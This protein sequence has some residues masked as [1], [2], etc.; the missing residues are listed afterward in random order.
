MICGIP[1]R[2]EQLVF[3]RI[4]LVEMYFSHSRLDCLGS[5]A[6]NHSLVDAETMESVGVVISIALAIPAEV[7]M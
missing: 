2:G 4:R 3:Q 5:N 6:D 7:A 1:I